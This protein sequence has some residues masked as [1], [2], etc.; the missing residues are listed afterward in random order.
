MVFRAAFPNRRYIVALGDP[1][2]WVKTK[3]GFHAPPAWNSP[4]WNWIQYNIKGGWGNRLVWSTLEMARR[5]FG[6]D[7]LIVQNN[8]LVGCDPC[9]EVGPHCEIGD[10]PCGCPG[11][12][13]PGVCEANPCPGDP[14]NYCSNNPEAACLC[15]PDP[16]HP[17]NK[18]LNDLQHYCLMDDRPKKREILN[19]MWILA[20]LHAAGDSLRTAWQMGAWASDPDSEHYPE[21]PCDLNKMGSNQ[22][23][24]NLSYACE[25]G[26]QRARLN[27]YEIYTMD[28]ANPLMKEDVQS[29]ASLVRAELVQQPCQ[30]PVPDCHHYDTVHLCCP[31]CAPG[32]GNCGEVC[33]PCQEQ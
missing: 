27:H 33:D 29:C 31:R 16:E 17:T 15:M 20:K 6:R 19:G 2:D 3:V 30:Y 28:L 7:R 25:R 26:A 14:T 9:E 22:P 24:P 21:L 18:C 10:A 4:T 13:Q 5:V 12:P 8:G 32:T 23:G 1:F 11:D